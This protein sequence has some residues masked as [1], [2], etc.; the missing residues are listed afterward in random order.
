MP[1]MRG[2]TPAAAAATIRARGV[3][4]ARRGFLRRDE[5][6]AGAIVDAGGV[7]R[8]HRAVGR[9]TG[10]QLCELLERGFRARMLVA[11]TTSGSPLRCGISTAISSASKKPR[12]YAAAVRCWLRSAN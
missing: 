1:M 8:G 12:A 6:R 2:S 7:A 11:V 10:W 4:P 9:E 5:Q 3:R